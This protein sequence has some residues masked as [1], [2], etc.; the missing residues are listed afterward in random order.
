MTE[1]AESMAQHPLCSD[2]L[3][4]CNDRGV[5][6]VAEAFLH[7]VCWI[8]N[9][10]NKCESLTLDT[11]NCRKFGLAVLPSPCKLHWS[12]NECQLRLG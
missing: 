10:L 2:V 9:N 12:V 8:C 6:V 1:A 11:F 7:E 5:V 4:K 3:A